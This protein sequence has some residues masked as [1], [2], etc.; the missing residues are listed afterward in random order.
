MSLK[1]PPPITSL[2]AWQA[3]PQSALPTGMWLPAPGVPTVPGAG[4]G[5]PPAPGVPANVVALAPWQAPHVSEVT[6]ECTIFEMP[7]P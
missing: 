3:V 5:W 6:A 4:S 1:P 7:G 2:E